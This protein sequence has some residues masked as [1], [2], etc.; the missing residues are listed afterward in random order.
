[1]MDGHCR[2]LLGLK[3]EGYYRGKGVKVSVKCEAHGD[4]N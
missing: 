4:H 1:M 2:T 3:K